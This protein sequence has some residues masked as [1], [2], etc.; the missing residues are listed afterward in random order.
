MTLSFDQDQYSITPGSTFAV[1][2]LLDPVP[3]VGLFSMGVKVTYDG[4]NAMV[5]DYDSIVLPAAINSIG[6]VGPP[7]KSIDNNSAGFS[8]ASAAA[9]VVDFIGYT[10]PLLVTIYLTD[11]T[12]ASATPTSYDLGL[13]FYFN[14]PTQANFVDF[15]GNVLDP[16]ITNMIPATV[17][18]DQ[19]YIIPAPPALALA[20]IGSLLT[21]TLKRRRLY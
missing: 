20:L 12:P 19:S 15:N 11:L 5:A 4:S 2:V 10:N 16:D 14:G 6:L 1:Q 9:G 18:V 7:L 13:D 17:M 21:I 8:F 3:S